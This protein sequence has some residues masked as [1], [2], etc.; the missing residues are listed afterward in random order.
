MKTRADWNAIR[1]QLEVTMSAE[2]GRIL[3]LL[4]A[5]ESTPSIARALGQHRSMIWRKVQ[6]LRLRATTEQSE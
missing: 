1:A 3:D 4:I 5:G 6:Q 2:E